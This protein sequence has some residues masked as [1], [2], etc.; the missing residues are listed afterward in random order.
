MA[1]VP[2]PSVAPRSCVRR[3]VPQ[4]VHMT[5][6]GGEHAQTVL[7]A[8]ER[9]EVIQIT[10]ELFPTA[11]GGAGRARLHVSCNGHPAHGSPFTVAVQ[12]RKWV[13]KQLNK[14]PAEGPADR[15]T[16]IYGEINESGVARILSWWRDKAGLGAGSVMIEAGSGR[17]KP[18]FLAKLGFR[19]GTV[20]GVEV[21]PERRF[22]AEHLRRI[23][24]RW[25]V[26]DMDSIRFLCA[27]ITVGALAAQTTPISAAAEND[28]DDAVDKTTWGALT[29]WYTFDTGFPPAVMEAI[30]KLVNSLIHRGGALKHFACFKAPHTLADHGFDMK[31]LRLAYKTIV[32]MEGSAQGHTCYVYSTDP[33]LF[34]DEWTEEEGDYVDPVT[35]EMICSSSEE[36]S[37]DSEDD[38]DPVSPPAEPQPLDEQRWITMQVQVPAGMRPGKICKIFDPEGEP[39]FVKI[40][41]LREQLPSGGKKAGRHFIKRIPTSYTPSVLRTLEQEE[42]RQWLRHRGRS[43]PRSTPHEAL[44]TAGCAYIKQ[45]ARPAPSVPTGWRAEWSAEY[46]R[47]YFVDL[48]A[49]L[50][51]WDNPS[52]AKKS[53][54]TKSGSGD[55]AMES[56]AP[57]GKGAELSAKARAAIQCLPLGLPWAEFHKLMGGGVHPS[58]EVVGTTPM[59]AG[60]WHTYQELANTA[61]DKQ[62]SQSEESQLQQ[63]TPGQQATAQSGTSHPSEQNSVP[64]VRQPMGRIDAATAEIDE[65]VAQRKAMGKPSSVCMGVSW[66][67][68]RRR[69]VAAIKHEN[70]SFNLGQYKT[71]AEAG[72]AVDAKAR[73]LRGDRAHGGGCAGGTPWSL[74]FPTKAEEALAAS[75]GSKVQAAQLDPPRSRKQ[76]EAAQSARQERG[77]E[78][79]NPAA[80]QPPKKVLRSAQQPAAASRKRSEGNKRKQEQA[81]ATTAGK[82]ADGPAPKRRTMAAPMMA[83]PPVRRVSVRN[84]DS[85]VSSTGRVRKAVRREGMV[86]I[87]QP[88]ISLATV[89]PFAHCC[90]LNLRPVAKIDRVPARSRRAA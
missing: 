57:V 43:L 82:E 38:V 55:G 64:S 77:V 25:G 76:A 21:V 35:L 33:A 18:C 51:T 73:L 31:V 86:D 1:S 36:E 79:V 11:P 52:P 7:M 47:W 19:V 9:H 71:E 41:G 16:P 22:I 74:N 12:P 8:R 48:G 59:M 4:L 61:V 5:A 3:A 89:R 24:L 81:P 30:G 62:G 87:T 69:W 45:T 50:S 49:Q 23:L 80:A 10:P 44:L 15:Y 42:L 17:G 83:A 66:S 60:I 34:L 46:K 90:P 27:D 75:R 70:K 37:S 20:I 88:G 84:T 40:P 39:H 2:D 72:R 32:N 67:K 65:L 6:S 68:H 56:P 63:P 14:A 26:L 53:R 28:A 54:V 85:T 29:H 78:P 58:H 13:W